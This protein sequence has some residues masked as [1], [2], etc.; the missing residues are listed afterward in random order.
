MCGMVTRWLIH[1]RESLSRVSI[2]LRDN[3][4]VITSFERTVD[5][6]DL[7]NIFSP[8]EQHVIARCQGHPS[9]DLFSTTCATSGRIVFGAVREGNDLLL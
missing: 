8:W 6:D 4:R 2:K 3:V 9:L 5:H 7:M 1:Y